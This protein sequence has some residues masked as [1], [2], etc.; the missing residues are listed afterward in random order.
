MFVSQSRF[1]VPNIKMLNFFCW[2]ALLPRF[3]ASL[4]TLH[5]CAHPFPHG[6]SSGYLSNRFLPYITFL[7]F[8][9]RGGVRFSRASPPRLSHY[10]HAHTRFHVGPPQATSQTAFSP[11]FG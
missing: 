10:T 9:F 7:I 4:V 6:P 11:F 8:F 1:S 5:P 2:R 3:S